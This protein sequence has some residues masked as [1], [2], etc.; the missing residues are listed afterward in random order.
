MVAG[1][2]V[3]MLVGMLAIALVQI[4]SATNDGTYA[5]ISDV[6]LTA[7]QEILTARSVGEGY[8]RVF[9]L[10]VDVQGRA[11][12]ITLAA[13]GNTSVVTVSL[14]SAQTS[15]RTPRCDGSLARGTNRITTTNTTITCAPV[16]P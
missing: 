1:F 13:D 16:V 10:P 5:G 12:A 6:A 2:A 11:Y 15:V 3:V 8:E 4:R 9:N 7:Q 14:G